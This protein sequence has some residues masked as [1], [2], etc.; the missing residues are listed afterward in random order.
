[1]RIDM[2]FC[3]A[4]AFSAMQSWLSERSSKENSGQVLAI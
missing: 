3:I 1:M 2:G 4:Y